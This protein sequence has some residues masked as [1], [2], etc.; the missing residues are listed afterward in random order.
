MFSA[1]H[2]LIQS[3]GYPLVFVLI[4]A[5]SGGLPV[6]GETTLIAAGALAAAGQLSIAAVIVVALAAAIIG[7][8]LGYMLARRYGRRLLERPGRFAHHRRR[9]LELGVPFFD[10][11][12]P[13][14]VFLARWIS[15]LR[16]WAAWLAGASGMSW[17]PFA[18]WNACGAI[19]WSTSVGLTAYVLGQS[20]AGLFTLV[21]LLVLG[22]VSLAVIA[23]LGRRRP[24]RGLSPSADV[25]P[26]M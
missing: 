3:A 18:V 9:V 26:E 6:P 10:R 17:R 24:S 25:A 15:G 19:A 14:A 4:L 20:T 7:D 11:H 1:I 13:K 16:T 22:A 21:G 23:A 5:E 8:N 2:T 12:G